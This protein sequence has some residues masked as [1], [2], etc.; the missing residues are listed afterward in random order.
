MKILIL[1][2]SFSNIGGAEYYV[3]KLAE[4]LLIIGND[5]KVISG[6]DF[7]ILP[8]SNSQSKSTRLYFQLL[9]L[10]GPS[11]FEI[12]NQVKKYN[13]DIVHIQNWARLRSSTVMR[14]SRMYPT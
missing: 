6:D 13:P 7:G 9:D 11:K 10:F 5:V 14:I 4:D 8:H 12:S 3:D 2:S 1:H